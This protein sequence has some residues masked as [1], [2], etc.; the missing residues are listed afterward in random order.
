[1]SLHKL[2][3]A[4]LITLL[5]APCKSGVCNDSW[6]NRSAY[7][8][9]KIPFKSIYQTALNEPHLDSSTFNQ[10]LFSTLSSPA[11]HH[12]YLSSDMPFQKSG[13]IAPAMK[14]NVA[15]KT[16]SPILAAVFSAIL[17]G[18]GEFY[19][20]SYWKSAL[21]LTAEVVGWS[22]Y[23]S[24]LDDGHNAEREFV[25][26]ANAKKTGSGEPGNWTAWDARRY[27]KHLS[28]IYKND[29][30]LGTQAKDLG[31]VTSLDKIGERNYTK[32]NAF[33]RI[34]TFENGNVF[35]HTLPEY[36]SQQYYELIG[37]YSTY[38]IG[39][40]DYPTS[41]LSNSFT[42]RNP[43]FLEYAQMRGH[44]N[45]L[46]KDA[47]TILSL[48]VVNHALSVADAIWSTSRYNQWVKTQVTLKRDPL[49]GELYPR[50]EL[51]VQF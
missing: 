43:S 3:L 45:S 20:E 19:A 44:A 11:E 18:A 38:T 10:D 40:Y 1:M 35:S 27:A 7:A 32:L 28:E 41:E 31:T 49:L 42:A 13:E 36:G 33:E 12:A 26:Y 6:S 51:S 37:K 50:A 48:I 16:R 24:K 30:N 15:P 34:A 47:S 21:F 4:L 14:P 39:W 2:S 8:Q 9:S 29:P 5:L 23:L 22:L 25:R 46:L 17:P